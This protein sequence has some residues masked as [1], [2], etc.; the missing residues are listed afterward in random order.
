MKKIKLISDSTCDL[1]NELIEQ[2]DIEIVPLYVSFD[3][4]SYKDGIDLSTEE[5][6]T[7]IKEKNTLPKTAAVAPGEFEVIFKKY[8]D[9][10]YDVVYMGIGSKFSGTFQSAHLAK[11]MLETE[12]VYLI[13]SA[14]LSS[15]TGLLLLKAAK[16]RDAGFS[17]LEIKEKVEALVPRVRSQFVIDTLDYLYKGGR[18]NALSALMGKMLR[19]HPLIIVRD[20]QMHVGKKAMGPMRK[21]LH[22]LL[23]QYKKD[24]ENMDEDFLM[25]THSMA[26]N[27][28]QYVRSKLEESSAVKNMYETHAGCVISTHCGAGTI[29]ILYIVKE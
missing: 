19:V 1:S 16:F 21:G 28:Y 29:G 15:G 17:A 27:H 25:I 6:Y 3:E 11:S 24:Q 8:L 26:D 10:G 9:L 23:D 14:N 2:H 18:L 20:G 5:M 13:D 12:D 4:E 22:V 7:L